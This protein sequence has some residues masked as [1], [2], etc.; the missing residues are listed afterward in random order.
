M[1]REAKRKGLKALSKEAAA[2][3][4][5]DERVTLLGYKS[6]RDYFLH[7]AEKT[8]RTMGSALGY[9]WMTVQKRYAQEF[10]AELKGE[11]HGGEQNPQGNGQGGN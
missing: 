7:N 11:K 4:S 9:T 6:V 2:G 3:H 8:F 1:A 5:F 10:A